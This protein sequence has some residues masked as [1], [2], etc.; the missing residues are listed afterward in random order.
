MQTLLVVMSKA[1]KNRK[2]KANRTISSGE[3][4]DEG[5]RT[6]NDDEPVE[7]QEDNHIGIDCLPTRLAFREQIEV[8]MRAH[9]FVL[10]KVSL[11]CI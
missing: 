7:D 2:R 10:L 3:P 1:R 5:K 11:L 4:S 9:C 6:R 8:G